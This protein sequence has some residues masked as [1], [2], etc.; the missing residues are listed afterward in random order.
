MAAF[1]HPPGS[2]VDRD[3]IDREQTAIRTAER[4]QQV[5]RW[6]RERTEE[7]P[8]QWPRLADQKPTQAAKRVREFLEW[9]VNQQFSATSPSQVAAALRTR[10]EERGAHVLQLKLS[11]EGCRGFSLADPAAPVLAVNSAYTVPARIFSMM[12]EVGH[13]IRHQQAFCSRLPDSKIERW[14]E[15][16]AAV[17]LMP[18]SVFTDYA[19]QR[20]GDE[21]VADIEQVTSMARKFKVSLR[22]AALRIEHLELGV[23][24][25]YDRVDAQADFKG[26]GGFSKDNTKPAI[27]IRE[28]G[29]SY[30]RTLADAESRGLLSHTDVLEYLN[31]SSRQFADVRER[32]DAIT[33]EAEG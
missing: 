24:G 18:R 3:L 27:R 10:I 2:Q 28:W 13:L 15:Q 14:C 23:A 25:L 9:D 29:P 17:F 22:A 12:H 11:Q 21:P 19:E 26:G 1:R 7:I 5:S 31:V 16:F 33:P 20:F 4:I 30:A 32:L 6:V 8:E